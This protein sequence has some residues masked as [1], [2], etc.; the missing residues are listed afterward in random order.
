[1]S[2]CSTALALAA[3]NE[4]STLYSLFELAGMSPI[5]LPDLFLILQDF[6]LKD[7]EQP[8]LTIRPIEMMVSAMSGMWRV[9]R[10]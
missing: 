1:M 7:T 10:C 6:F 2:T 5:T 4:C 9:S 8:E 3:V